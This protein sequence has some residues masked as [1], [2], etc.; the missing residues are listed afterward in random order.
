MIGDDQIKQLT[1][2]GLN[3]YEAKAY[4]A[5][6]RK[7]SFSASQ[8][9]DLSGVPRQRIYDILASLVERGLAISRPGKHGTRY[10]AVAPQPALRSLLEQEQQRLNNI[11]ITTDALIRTL[12]AQ[13]LQGKTEHSPLEYIEVL[14]G[15]TAINQRFAEIQAN[16]QREILIFT[17]PP[18]AKPVSENQ[19]GIKALD[20]HVR[21]CSLYEYNVLTNPEARDAISDFISHGEEARFVEHLPLKLVI[22]DEEIVMFAMEDPV[23]G[24]T[25]LTIMVIDHKQLARL[26]KIAF[27]TLWAQGETFEQA[28]ARLDVRD[29]ANIKQVG[30][31]VMPVTETWAAHWSPTAPQGD[32]IYTIDLARGIDVLRIERPAADTPAK[33]APVRKQWINET[34]TEWV[35]SAKFSTAHESFQW[36][37][38]VPNVPQ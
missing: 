37:C 16:C 2:L 7:E 26:M 20:R 4:I 3:V 18:Y 32:I 21:A 36:A 6:L 38:R 25:D 33:R 14:R 12:G 5:L 22:V 30:Y 11:Q 13:Y 35:P 17:K 1:Q 29:P 27:E 8:V 23:A 34:S 9:A 19:E 10:A 15:Q 31:F 28:C 24:R